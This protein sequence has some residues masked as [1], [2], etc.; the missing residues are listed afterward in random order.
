MS[1]EVHNPFNGELIAR[2][3]VCDAAALDRAAAIANDAFQSYR[4]EPAFRRAEW[5]TK[6]AGLLQHRRAE[7]AETIMLE[8]GKPITLAEAEVDRA[9]WTFL[10]AA[11]EARRFHGEPIVADAFPSGAGH[12]AIAKRFPIGVVYGITPF[13]FPLNLVAH[14]VAAALACGNTIIIKPSPRTP[15][16]ALKLQEAFGEVGLP[17]GVFQVVTSPNEL[18]THLINDQR[19]RYISFTGSVPVGWTI[20]EQAARAKKRCTLELGGN[21]GCI[22]H[23]DADLD[24]AI[25]MIA[26]G[27]FSYAGQSCISVQRVF[28]Y[29]NLRGQFV[30]RL[31]KYIEENI[32]CGDP[33]DR[34]VMVGPMIDRDAQQ[35]VLR[36]I[37]DA[38]NAGAQV[39]CGGEADGACIKPT[40]IVGAGRR[41]TCARKRSSPPS[42]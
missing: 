3:P 11:D 36:A 25:P 16:S 41:P 17:T 33:R 21:A 1:I 7:F 32:R 24:A 37:D 8:A 27:A 26:R 20:N 13:N 28:L 12:V 40:V 23:D 34:N 19:I 6:I 9:A 4:N 29:Q 22:V 38:R 14:K 18:T 5:L 30:P 2:V 15:L 42:S 35:R 39:L 10:S 31:L